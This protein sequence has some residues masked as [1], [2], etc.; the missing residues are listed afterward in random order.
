MPVES[1]Q[2]VKAL[3]GQLYKSKSWFII[4]VI[5]VQITIH[6]SKSLPNQQLCG[7]QAGSFRFLNSQTDKT[8]QW[9]KHT[10]TVKQHE[11]SE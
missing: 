7:N 4:L 6:T 3:Q 8:L 2:N 9:G 1:R 10:Y 11:Q 5:K